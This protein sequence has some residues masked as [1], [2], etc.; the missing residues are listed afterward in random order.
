MPKQYKDSTRT[1]YGMGWRTSG[2]GIHEEGLKCDKRDK[3]LDELNME[4]NPLG[5]R[6]GMLVEIVDLEIVYKRTSYKKW[7]R[8]SMTP[9]GPGYMIRM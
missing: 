4:L 3:C 6:K 7:E 9:T 1:L 5:L 8:V 2:R